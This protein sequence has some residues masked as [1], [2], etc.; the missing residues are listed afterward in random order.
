M[1]A[2]QNSI[3]QTIGTMAA[4]AALGKKE[5][6]GLA[7]A[8]LKGQEDLSFSKAEL[9]EAQAREAESGLAK[10]EG[11]KRVEEAQKAYDTAMAKRPGGKGNTKEAIAER[12]KQTLDDLTAAQKA[13]D[14]LDKK[15][16]A[17]QAMTARW[18]ERYDNISKR[19]GGIK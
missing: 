15:N 18:Q 12:Q 17:A 2:I 8:K 13:F 3:N 16:I 11:Q 1:G 9:A 4:A 5:I 6:E 7:E 10:E 14:V 19:L